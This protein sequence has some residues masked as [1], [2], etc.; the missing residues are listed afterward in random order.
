MR[1]I[2]TDKLQGMAKRAVSEMKLPA[3][4]EAVDLVED[5]S[6]DLVEE[7]ET[8]AVANARAADAVRERVEEGLRADLQPLGR[9]L[10][11]ALQAGDLVAMQAAARKISEQMPEF[12][13]SDGLAEALAEVMVRAMVEEE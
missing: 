2:N 1:I 12:L 3:R 8:E 7:E 11:G 9:A 4:V 6:G 5:A 13:E 10:A